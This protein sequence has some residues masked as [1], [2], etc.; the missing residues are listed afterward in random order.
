MSHSI[1]RR[2]FVTISGASLAATI[3]LGLAACGG[4]S[5]SGS[6][7]SKSGSSSSKEVSGNI[8]AVGSTALQPLVEAAAEQYMNDNPGVQITVQGGGSGQGI[9]Q[10]AQGAVQIGDSDVF[11]EE[12]L[13]NKDDAKKLKDNKVAVVGM[14]P[15]VHPDVKVDDLTI[16]QL[17]GI[18]TGKVTNWK[19]VGGDDK[20]IVVINRAAGSGTRATFE[21]AVLGG[22]KVPEDFKPQEQDSSGTVVKMVAQTPNSISYLAFSY[23]SDDVKALRVGGVEPK[24][25][26]VETNDWTIW[27]YEH[28][29]TAAKPDAATADFIKYMLSDDVQGSLVKKTGYIS[30]KGMKVERDADGNVTK[31]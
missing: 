16:D 30:T 2:K 26:N 15:V 13:E 24:D 5:D 19:E 18:F 7:A 1:S 22:D 6:D 3:G 4:S 14:G 12:K 23:F 11:A 29:Y 27:A 25:E 20:E 8:T 9:T 31:L 10:I 28:M 21:N 17:K